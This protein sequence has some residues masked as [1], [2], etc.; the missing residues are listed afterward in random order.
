MTRF[1]KSA[2]F[3]TE[4]ATARRRFLRDGLVAASTIPSFKCIAGQSEP[5]LSESA[6][7]I[8]AARTETSNYQAV[9]LDG[10]GYPTTTILLPERAH[11]GAAHRQT[12]VAAVFARRPGY[13]MCCFDLIKPH[14]AV[15][16]S[17]PPSRHFYGHGVY[18]EN[19]RYLLATEN[20]FD[21]GKGVV[22][23]YDVHN[24][25]QRFD[26]LNSN[27]I[28]PHDIIKIPDQPLIVI[29]NGGIRTHP[30][31]GR[32]KLNLATMQPSLSIVDTNS[33]ALVGHHVLEEQYHQLSVRHLAYDGNG[34]VWF[35]GQF[36]GTDSLPITLAGSI[37]LHKSL[38]DFKAGLSRSGL[39]MLSMPE[40]MVERAKGYLSS[41]AC[42]NQFIAF[43]SSR[44]GFAFMVDGRSGRISDELSLLDCSGI[45]PVA[46]EIVGNKESSNMM[47]HRAETMPSFV[48]TSGTGDMQEFPVSKALFQSSNRYQWDNHLYAI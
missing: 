39:N 19:G 44:G 47:E 10:Q 30:K 43:T 25:Y 17:P 28:G 27:G 35:A 11:G 32:D 46:S 21:S 29:A 1:K 5:T 48:V 36:E 20:N 4:L 23:I 18:I 2:R 40:S 22:G 33:G 42:F 31:S 45:A 26:E 3:N 9:L 6:R 12:G 41:V 16:V 14:A 8:T 24:A 38:I 37:D 7:Y 34:T 13:Y 15:F